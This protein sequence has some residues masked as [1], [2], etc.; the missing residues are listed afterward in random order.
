MNGCPNGQACMMGKCANIKADL[1]VGGD[2][3][4]GM[5]DLAAIHD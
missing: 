4:P 1:G 2:G 5:P 3:G